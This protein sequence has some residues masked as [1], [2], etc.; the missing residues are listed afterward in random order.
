MVA[1]WPDVQECE[2]PDAS[3]LARRQFSGSKDGL[4]RQRRRHQ[5]AVACMVGLPDSAVAG[6]SADRDADLSGVRCRAPCL[7]WGHDCRLS[8]SEDVKELV[9]ALRALSRS[10]LGEL[11][12]AVSRRE[13]DGP[14]AVVLV[15]DVRQQA[16]R[17]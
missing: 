6:A 5:T 12:L 13:L 7:E 11:Q 1:T 17:H 8:A 16:A 15:Q 14:R 9:T 10:L 3:R 4:F 2:G